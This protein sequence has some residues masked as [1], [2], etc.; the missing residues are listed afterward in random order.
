M[1]NFLLFNVNHEFEKGKHAR[2]VNL[3]KGSKHLLLVSIT[4]NIFNKKN[5][6]YWI[7]PERN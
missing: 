5:A 7:L 2:P 3:K 4:T 1:T 6:H